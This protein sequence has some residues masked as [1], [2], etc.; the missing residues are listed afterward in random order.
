MSERIPCGPATFRVTTEDHAERI[1]SLLE[2]GPLTL[3]ELL[4][5]VN[6]TGGYYR[7]RITS[8]VSSLVESG[9]VVER[10]AFTPRHPAD[11]PLV[12]LELAVTP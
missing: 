2:P 12:L 3:Q 1:A 10:H 7:E 9:R 5:C 4:Y 8:A 11:K 6:A